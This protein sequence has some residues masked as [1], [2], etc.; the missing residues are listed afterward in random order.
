MLNRRSFLQFTSLGTASVFTSKLFATEKKGFRPIVISTW[1]EGINAN[2]AAWNILRSKGRA[3]DA[4]EAGVMVTEASQNCCVGL[5]ANPDR[6]GIV[7]LDASIMDEHGNCG[8]VGALE[9]IKHPISVARR[10]ME[11]TPHVMLVG[12]GAQK[13]AI[14][15]GFPLEPQQLSAD[16]ERSYKEWLKKSEYKP[17]INIENKGH[18]PFAPLHLENGD[19]NHDTIGMV[20]LDAMSNLSG[21]C[22]TSGMG[23]KMRGRL[24]DSPIIGAGLYVDNEVGAAT[25]TGL[26]EEVIKICGT[27][28]VVEFMRQGNNPET[29]C[30][31]AVERIVKRDKEKAKNTQ[32]G[33]IAINKKGEFGGYCLQKGFNY[34]VCYGDDTNFMVDAKHW[35]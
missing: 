7:T 34:A 3:L 18:G 8:C 16:A 5:G 22:T 31:K 9:R 23:F 19:W 27:H 20:A 13:F 10:V 4:V 35:F 26:G 32:V 24:G 33:F 21:S 14:A 6:D 29:A 17:V 28:L 11:K 25:A 30:R 12:E 15:E 2:K 1:N